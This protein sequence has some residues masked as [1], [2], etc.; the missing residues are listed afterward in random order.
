MKRS[1]ARKNDHLTGRRQSVVDIGQD[2]S[3]S[4]VASPMTRACLESHMRRLNLGLSGNVLQHLKTTMFSLNSSAN[5]LD[6]V[7][8]K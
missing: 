7:S 4:L 6:N 5:N 3:P 2:F 8:A 1:H